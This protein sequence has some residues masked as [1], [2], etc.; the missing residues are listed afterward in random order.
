ME[1]NDK[2]GYHTNKSKMALDA[3]NR[4]SIRLTKLKSHPEELSWDEIQILIQFHEKS[5]KESFERYMEAE[6]WLDAETKEIDPLWISEKTEKLANILLGERLP[7][8]F[9]EAG[10]TLIRSRQKITKTMLRATAIAYA[11]ELLWIDPSPI[12]DKVFKILEK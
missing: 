2:I 4:H 9:M 10:E 6:T 7:L 8:D 1:R 5:Y 12:R 11:K 3:M